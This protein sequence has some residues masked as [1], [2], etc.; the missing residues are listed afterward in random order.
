MPQCLR[1]LWLAMAVV[2]G[3]VH[4]ITCPTS[5]MA[6]NPLLP[7][8]LTTTT[9]APSATISIIVSVTPCIY[10]SGLCYYLSNGRLDNADSTSSACFGFAQSDS[11]SPFPVTG[12]S[13][14]TSM[15]ITTFKISATTPTSTASHIPTPTSHPLNSNSTS[16][17]RDLSSPT[18][19]ISN[20]FAKGTSKPVTHSS[21]S[22]TGHINAPS[23]SPQSASPAPSTATSIASSD[24]PTIQKTTRNNA[25]T[26][27]IA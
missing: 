2:A 11:E 1:S 4:A 26:A 20:R 3:L 15:S 19:S 21:A 10:S 18:S 22:G 13:L 17:N 24:V 6:G 27:A 8:D 7:G 9:S 12:R 14:T 23:F 25:P 5:D 16:S